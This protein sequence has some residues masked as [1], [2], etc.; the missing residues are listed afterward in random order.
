MCF[1]TA[2]FSVFHLFLGLIGFSVW[3]DVLNDTGLLGLV[4]VSKAVDG[5]P[6]GTCNFTMPNLTDVAYDSN[7]SGICSVL[8]YIKSYLQDLWLGLVMNISYKESQELL[9]CV[10]VSCPGVL[11]NIVP[12]VLSC[13][14]CEVCWEEFSI[15][16]KWNCVYICTRVYFDWNWLVAMFGYHLEGCMK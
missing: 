14:L 5:V 15:S 1:L 8:K 6:L 12:S 2:G 7:Y 11:L 3:I 4:M 10:I 9:W 16:A 13:L